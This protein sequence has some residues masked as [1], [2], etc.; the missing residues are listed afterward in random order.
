MEFVRPKIVIS[1]CL[2][3]AA[4]YYSGQIF[5]IKF[6][7][8]LGEFVE[9]KPV[10]PELEIGLGVPRPTIRIVKDKEEI[11]LI[12]PKTKEDL[13]KKMNDFSE[14]FLNKFDYIDGF[15]FKSRSP[16]C[17]FKDIKVYP[18]LNGM[19]INK[20]GVGLFAKK[21]MNVYP[22]AVV[23]SEGRLNNLRL[24]EHFLSK[25][26]T[27]A[28]FRTI[29]NNKS[30][31]DLVKYHTRHKY[32]FMA[33]NQNILNE[34]GNITA[35]H[36]NK[37]EQ[38]VY[39]LYEKKLQEIFLKPPTYKS[40]INVLSHIYGYF[41]NK[42]SKNEKKFF[43]DIVEKYRDNKVNLA[44]PIHLLRAWIIEYDVSYLKEQS[45]INPFPKELVDLTDSGKNNDR[46]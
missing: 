9:F 45:F 8:K 3:F 14:K 10:C 15:I 11:R 7:D 36:A 33:Y 5:N 41:K 40:I 21:A 1:K 38:E 46:L 22:K 28:E 29:E 35:N 26:Y 30:M 12:Q 43:I 39:S 44:V 37:K 17:G 16:S 6:I 32:L 42:L 20:E 19:V 31:Q 24:R 13:T 2:G 34:L 25:L 18:S 4:C 23:E 27:L